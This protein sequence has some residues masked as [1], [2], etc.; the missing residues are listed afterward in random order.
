MPRTGLKLFG[1]IL[2]LV[3]GTDVAT[4]FR[5]QA[6]VTA[7]RQPKSRSAN[8]GWSTNIPTRPSRALHQIG[9]VWFDHV[10]NGRVDHFYFEHTD[11]QALR[12]LSHL[13]D[14]HLCGTPYGGTPHVRHLGEGE[15]LEDMPSLNTLKI[16]RLGLG[17][18][19]TLIVQR[20]RNLQKLESEDTWL[21]RA[22]FSDL[23]SLQHLKLRRTHSFRWGACQIDL[24]NLPQL[25]QLE[26]F[27]DDGL[28]KDGTFRLKDLAGLKSIDAQQVPITR[29]EFSNLPNLTHLEL[30]TTRFNDDGARTLCGLKNLVVLRLVICDITDAGLDRLDDLPSLEILD[31]R[32]TGVTAQGLAK[33][34]RFP[35]LRTIVTS[36]ELGTDQLRELQR[37]LPGV[38]INTQVLTDEAFD[39]LNDRLLHDKVRPARPISPGREL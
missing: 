22:R 1:L 13:R 10:S 31:L 15:P 14:L 9:I 29:I 12:S 18:D 11:V 20:C 39:E 16:W 21:S 27:R 6:A 28:I 7:L 4:H 23:P 2:L 30:R 37:V 26:I 38:I 17:R 35:R 24:I 5:E 34:G 25:R 3:M 19:E 33:L 8:F 36:L 32:L